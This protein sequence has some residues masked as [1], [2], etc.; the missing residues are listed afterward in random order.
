M[1]N[2]WTDGLSETER[3][4]VVQA[5]K[6]TLRKPEGREALEY[7]LNVR[8]FSNVIIDRFDMGYC[9]IDVDHD[10]R[11]RII[12]P[13]YDAYM[14][15]IAISTRHLI[16]KRNFLHEPFIKGSYLY[17][18]CYAKKAI[19]RTNNVII[20]EGEFDVAYFHSFGFDM[21]IGLCGS[22]FSLFQMALLSKYCTN[23]Y[24]MFDGDEA[25]RNSIKRAM[26][27]YDKYDLA[28]YKINFIPVYLPA[29]TDPD[30]YLMKE[31]RR[32]MI[33]K[34]KISKEDCKIKI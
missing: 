19:Q 14:N 5:A 30:E 25:G 2:I 27:D 17:G 6:I 3:Q 21:T 15:L 7:L 34:L 29:K 22:A 24:L 33:D 32:N 31:G 4:K 28:A 1:A 9:P 12:T 8:K 16:Q 20:V 23:Y 10:V 26:K 11:G 13:I 18:L